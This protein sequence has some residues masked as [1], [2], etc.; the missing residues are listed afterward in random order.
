MLCVVLYVALN[1]ADYPEYLYENKR[2]KIY[3]TKH[4]F[5]N[6]YRRAQAI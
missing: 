2:A 1:Y 4:S 5:Y 3:K 6:L